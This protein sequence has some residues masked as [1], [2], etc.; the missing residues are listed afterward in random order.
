MGMIKVT[1]NYLLYIIYSQT[2]CFSE[3]KNNGFEHDSTV[4]NQGK[5]IAT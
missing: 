1:L 2:K 5:C 3:N 4:Y